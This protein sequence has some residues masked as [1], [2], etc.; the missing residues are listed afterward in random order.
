MQLLNW[1]WYCGSGTGSVLGL[2][3]FGGCSVAVQVLMLFCRCSM[4][5]RMVSWLLVADISLETFQTFRVDGFVV[6]ERVTRSVTLISHPLAD[7]CGR[8][9]SVFTDVV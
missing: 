3:L 7:L 5:V 8:Y 9:V 2:M 1:Y 6:G 4:A